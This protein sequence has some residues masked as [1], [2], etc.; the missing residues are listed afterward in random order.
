M[1]KY[2]KLVGYGIVIW[3]VAYIVATIFVVLN[4]QNTIL[5]WM[6]TALAALATTFFLA[7][8]LNISSVK[9]ILKYA[10]VWVIT[11]F[12][13]DA[14]ITTH[15]IG[16]EFFKSWHIWVSYALSFAVVILAAKLKR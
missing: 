15:F 4:S 11:G 10:V 16:W 2:Y 1:K 3:V 5:A 13:L 12:I 6:A 8:S 14:L 9:E 7:R